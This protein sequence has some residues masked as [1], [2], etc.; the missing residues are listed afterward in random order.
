MSDHENEINGESAARSEGTAG[1]E[2]ET[3]TLTH[4]E[5]GERIGEALAAAEQ[6]ETRAAATPEGQ[7]ADRRAHR[8]IIIAAV[9]FA[10]LLIGA[11]I[12]YNVLAGDEKPS[13]SGRDVVTTTE[14]PTDDTSANGNG[15]NAAEG[16]GS[17][18]SDS[19]NAT[20][21]PEFTMADTEGQTLTLADFRGKPVLL[22]FWA[23]WCG[24]CASEMPAIQSAYEQYG[25]Q[26]QFVAVNM[27]GMG[28]ETETSALSLIQQNNYTFPV[29]FDVDS[30]AAVAFGVTSIPQTYLI[31][32]KGN[33]IGGLRGAMSDNVL[34]E[35]IQMLLGNE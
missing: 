29:Y 22:N 31:D 34:A 24:P 27:T 1:S 16:D 30:S 17:G 23:S 15:A 13:I 7:Q 26:I 9:A 11:G 12:A 10:V 2:V 6:E 32:A 35:G 19:A 18:A 5:R 3:K 33:I 21:A 20:A 4:E 8:G 14:V 28:G 25:D